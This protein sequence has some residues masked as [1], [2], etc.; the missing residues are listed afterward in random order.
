MPVNIG[1]EGQPQEIPTQAHKLEQDEVPTSWLTIGTVSS[2]LSSHRHHITLRSK[3][4]PITYHTIL[5]FHFDNFSSSQERNVEKR[6]MVECHGTNDAPS[7]FSLPPTASHSRAKRNWYAMVA[8]CPHLGAPLESAAVRR[9]ERSDKS[10]EPDNKDD[11][12]SSDFS[13][14]EEEEEEIEDAVIVCPWHEYDF[15][16]STGES[17]TGMNA[18]VYKVR[19]IGG[20]V[21]DD[22]DNLTATVQVENMR[23]DDD[24]RVSEWEIVEIRAVSEAFPSG[25]HSQISTAE[26]LS[27]QGLSLKDKEDPSNDEQNPTSASRNST[28]VDA[29]AS[30]SVLPPE[31]RPKTLVAWACLILNT[32]TPAKK[33]AYTRMAADAFRSGECKIIGGGRWTKDSDG[34][35]VWTRKAD[36]T[37]PEYPPREEHMKVVRPG[38]EQRRGKGGSERSRVAMLHSLANIELYAIELGWDLIARSPELYEKFKQ[39]HQPYAKEQQSQRLPLEF[40]NDFVKLSVDEAKHFSL[41]VERIH[42]INGTNF[43]DLEVHQGLWDTAI[44]TKHSLTARLSI[45]HLVHESRGLDANPMTIK[46]FANAKDEESTKVLEIIHHDEITHVGIGNRHL[47]YLCALPNSPLQPIQVFREEVRR[48]FAGRLKGPFN[49]EDRKKAGLEREWYEDLVGQR[50]EL[51]RGV[52][53]EEI[54]GG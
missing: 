27:I 10:Q 13:F 48:N 7:E 6:S 14:N 15:D 8:Q 28:T 36:E 37:P 20:A 24:D 35:K 2:L 53:R 22:G 47:H 52:A 19:T 1:I 54:A 9:V 3:T 39:E 18:C 51:I 29:K 43:G 49:T 30:S 21:Q 16:L 11:D 32:P 38:S 31:P 4:K 33:V 46:K 40:Y 26:G 17:S 12:A 41:L 42:Q 23:R 44:Q 25:P 34:K 45:V 5:L 50:N